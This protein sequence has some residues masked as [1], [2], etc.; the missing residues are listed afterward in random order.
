M[1]RISG[2]SLVANLDFRKAFY[3][4]MIFGSIDVDLVAKLLKQRFFVTFSQIRSFVFSI[5]PFV[6]F[7][8]RARRGTFRRTKV[9]VSIVLRHK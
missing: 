9:H 8:S 6:P 1:T 2:A 7:A 5:I 3:F 4:A